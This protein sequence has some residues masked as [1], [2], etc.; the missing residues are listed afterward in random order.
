[1]IWRNYRGYWL[2][3]YM[4]R[5]VVIWCNYGVE[6]WCD[7]TVDGSDH[8]MKLW[9]RMM[10]GWTCGGVWWYETVENSDLWRR[11]TIW[12]NCGGEW[13]YETV[14]NSDLLRTVICRG[15]RWYDETVKENDETFLLLCE[16]VIKSFHGCSC[17]LFPLN[18]SN[19]G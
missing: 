8:V 2:F 12:W 9:R 7:E 5:R 3:D 14:E 1:M 19:S 11:V 4:W 16:F 17:F 13:W 18:Q 15:G 10:M 6:W